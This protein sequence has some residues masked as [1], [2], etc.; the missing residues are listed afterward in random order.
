MIQSKQLSVFTSDIPF[1][2]KD[3]PFSGAGFCR[4]TTQKRLTGDTEERS[5]REELRPRGVKGEV[6]EDTNWIP[7]SEE[8]C[9]SESN[10]SE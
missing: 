4:T 5:E 2:K 7:T 10:H 6:P 3:D 1:S 8:K 9:C